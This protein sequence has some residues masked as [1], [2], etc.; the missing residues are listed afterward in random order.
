MFVYVCV[1]LF[2]TSRSRTTEVEAADLMNMIRVMAGS[3]I[4]YSLLTNQFRQECSHLNNLKNTCI[5]QLV[6][7]SHFTL[8]RS[9]KNDIF[10]WRGG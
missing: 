2:I 4:S 10:L 1:C 6:K 7:L 5:F 9:E 8:V 3:P